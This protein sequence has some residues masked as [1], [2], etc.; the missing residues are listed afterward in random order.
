MR[1][2]ID[3]WANTSVLEVG[4]LNLSRTAVVS[5][6]WM[7]LLVPSG[8][9]MGRRCDKVGVPVEDRGRW[10]PFHPHRL[11]MHARSDYWSDDDWT[12]KP[13]LSRVFRFKLRFAP[14]SPGE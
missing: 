10:E 2:R 9:R 11:G 12:F 14:G 7:N 4:I 8:I 1:V 13:D 5:D 6:A 3:D